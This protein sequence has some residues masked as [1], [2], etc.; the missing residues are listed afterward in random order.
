M[1][2]L[3]TE[4]Y[5]PISSLEHGKTY[6]QIFFVTEIV[7]NSKMV[8]QQGKPFARVTFKDTTGEISGVVWDYNDQLEEGGYFSVSVEIR[9]YRGNIEFACQ[10]SDITPVETP[11][12][13]YDYITGVNE[14][15]L[16]AYANEIHDEITSIDDPIYRDIMGNAVE[17]LNMIYSLMASP[18]GIKGPM[19][20]RGGLIVHVAHS[21]RLAKVAIQQARELEIPFSPSLVIAGCVL[22]NIG[23]HTTTRFQGDHL[24]PRDAY[25]MIGVHRASARYINHLMLTTES[26][27]QIEIPE[28]KK[29]AL[30]NMC[31]TQPDIMTL[32]GKIVSCADNMA[33]VLDFSV[34]PLQRKQ[35]GS[36][37]DELFTAHLG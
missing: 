4:Q 5:I 22:R 27:L 30:E 14:A 25:H 31:N 17:D 6:E 2:Q 19:A 18:Y 11:L 35:I 7:H 1:S 28:S 12:N 9:P 33:D 32:E 37:N 15:V 24:R 26:N 8:T 23:W 21:L 34:S 36:W 13:Q 29:Q 16:Q 3:G 20:Y 10:A